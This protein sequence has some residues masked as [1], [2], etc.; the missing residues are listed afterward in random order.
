MYAYLQWR[1][2][3]RH[4]LSQD[5]LE[6]WFFMSPS[7]FSL[8]S[9]MSPLA[10][11]SLSVSRLRSV[12]WLHALLVHRQHRILLKVRSIGM[13]CLF[14]PHTARI[15]D[16]LMRYLTLAKCNR[17]FIW[18]CMTVTCVWYIHASWYMVIL[19]I[20]GDIKHVLRYCSR[21]PSTLAIAKTVMFWSCYFYFFP[22]TD[23]WTFLCRF[24]RNFSTR[25]GMSWNS[26]SPIGVFISA[27]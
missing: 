13:D 10:F 26:L 7:L 6:I 2:L 14:R 1:S 16:N 8:E 5:C 17:H 15:S 20:A 12:W 22:S 25:R 19:G 23:F 3:K 18:H 11:V 9:C 24:S 4:V 27:F 21:P